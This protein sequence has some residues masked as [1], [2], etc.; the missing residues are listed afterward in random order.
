MSPAV[1]DL[2]NSLSEARHSTGDSLARHDVDLEFA[3]GHPRFNDPAH[4]AVAAQH[5]ALAAWRQRV[6]QLGARAAEGVQGSYAVAV[7]SPQHG[8]CD[9]NAKVHGARNLYVC[10]GSLIPA[11]GVSNTGLTIAA[12]ALRLAAHLR[13]T[14]APAVADMKA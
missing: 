9:V 8:V 1:S 6:A 10:D 7:R 4:Q 13:A 12:L 5:G 14:A 11:S 3:V 2:P